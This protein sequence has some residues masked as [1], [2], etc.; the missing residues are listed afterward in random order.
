M[1]FMQKNNLK[2]VAI[3][4]AVGLINGFMGGGGGI[5]VVLALTFVVG[6]SQKNAQ[7]TAIF[8]ILPVSI[9]SAIIYIVGGNVDWAVTLYAT[10]GV[11]LGGLVGS[12]LLNKIDD[13]WLKLFFSC[14]LIFAGIRMFF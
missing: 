13:K 5:F 6:M 8:I 10:I 2:L 3:G 11:V 9:A 4:C 1:I 14:I 12:F 7:A